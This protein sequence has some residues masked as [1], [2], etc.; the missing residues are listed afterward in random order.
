M[1]L[2]K[3]PKHEAIQKEVKHANPILIYSSGYTAPRTRTSMKTLVG[4]VVG[5]QMLVQL[6]GNH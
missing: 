2:K 6:S 3:M 1:D 4:N 5:N